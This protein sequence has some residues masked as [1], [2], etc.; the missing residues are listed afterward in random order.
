MESHDLAVRQPRLAQLG[1]GDE[2]ELPGCNPV[3][4]MVHAIQRGTRV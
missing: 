4:G 1:D 2:A 3:N